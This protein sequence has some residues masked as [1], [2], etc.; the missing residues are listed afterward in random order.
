M[1]EPAHN[2]TPIVEIAG[3]EVG[4]GRPCFVIAEAGVNH[5]GDSALAHQLVDAAR[6]AGADAVKFQMFRA[7]S[8]VTAEAEKAG[9]Q[10]ASTKSGGAQLD[11]L[12]ALELDE[13][14]HAALKR[15]CDEA[16]LLY[17]CTPYDEESADALDRLGVAAY[18][19][20]STDTANIPFL[21]HIAATGRPVILSTGMSTLEDVEVAMDALGGPGG[22][23]RTVVLHCTSEYPAPF[24]ESNLR[25]MAALV[26][27]TGCPVGFSDH[28]EG[29]GAA[30]YA[31]A[32][33]A[34]CIEKH[35][36]LD[37]SM[38][39]PDH[40]ASLEPDVFR[41]L[42]REIRIVEAALGDGI[43]RVMPSEAA[44]VAHVRKSVV[45]RVAIS[46]G[47]VIRADMLAAKRPG[48]GLEPQWIDR[49][50][51]RRAAR[52]IAVDEQ[53]DQASVNWD[54]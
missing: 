45:A 28:T 25:A 11:M 32:L 1:A 48:T 21:R 18:K 31:V 53:L 37:R 43:K 17:L 15:H 12:R 39:G 16:G 33:G 51:G 3:R 14:T 52:D 36:T 2:P 54:E 13:E 22:N 9:Y 26:T 27:A 29:P 23:G 50:A 44:N 42:V 35:F 34:C 6:D 8:L 38:E 19:V 46:A 47:T 4:A 30:P 41:E 5:N 7:D 49:I 24:A 10:K 20:G 40:Q